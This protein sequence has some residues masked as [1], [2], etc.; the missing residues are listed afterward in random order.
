MQD[1]ET[2]RLSVLYKHLARVRIWGSKVKGQGHQWHKNE[3][4]RHFF[5]SGP[6]GYELCHPP[7]LRRWKNQRMLSS[8]ET[9]NRN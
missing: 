4:V 1:D 7:V 9:R 5:R 2:W 3:K 6:R 8:L